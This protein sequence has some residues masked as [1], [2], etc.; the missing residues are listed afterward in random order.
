MPINAGVRQYQKFD[1][2]NT[3]HL[4]FS[5]VHNILDGRIIMVREPFDLV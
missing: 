3:Y 4:D 1:K 5:S 2:V